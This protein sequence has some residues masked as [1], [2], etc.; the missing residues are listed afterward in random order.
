MNKILILI[1]YKGFF[2]SK[3][4]SELY[5]GGMDIPL[6]QRLFKDFGFEV[7]VMKYSELQLQSK[8]IL[9]EKPI[10][11]YQSSE[12][13]NSFYKSYIEDI[14]F[15]L[16]QRG[17]IAVP[18]YG[19]LKAHNNKAAMELLRSRI[20]F[21]PIETIET[22]VFGVLEEVLEV[23]GKIKYPAVVKPAWGAKSRGV[24]LVQNEKELIDHVKKISSSSSFKHDFKEFL[25]K[26]KYRRNYIKESFNRNKFVIQNLIPNLSNDWKVLVYGNYA[27]ALYRHVRDNDFRASGSGKFIFKKELPQGMLDYALSV[28]KAFNVPHIS[29]DIAFDGQSFHLIEFQFLNFGTTT[30]EKSNFYF[31]MENNQWKLHEVKANLE[32]IYTTSTVE[33]INQNYI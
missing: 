17:I 26:V 27:F 6:L 32:E 11:L 31:E 8:G 13:Q 25:R 15:D 12:D 10:V 5:R 29:L 3:Q 23:K 7:E 28:R 22:M 1:D 21:A 33:Y 2:G 9:D 18:S 14:I 24:S 16:E 20:D 4:Y 30:L 19:C